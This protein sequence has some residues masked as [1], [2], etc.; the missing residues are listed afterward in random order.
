M[1]GSCSRGQTA[2][3]DGRTTLC[4]ENA[5]MGRCGPRCEVLEPRSLASRF[6]PAEASRP[7]TLQASE[8]IEPFGPTTDKQPL[9]PLSWR[10]EGRARLQK[11]GSLSW[12]LP[13]SA[14]V[15]FTGG[16]RPL[17][18]VLLFRALTSVTPRRGAGG[19]HRST[20]W[21]AAAQRWWPRGGWNRQLLEVGNGW[22]VGQGTC[23]SLKSLENQQG[24]HA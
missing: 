8:C 10:G 1:V 13:P 15:P 17:G 23:C 7:M 12:G 3:R 22:K 20:A 19:G 11:S 18:T 21:Q 24:K 5:S 2:H 14:L 4:A 16:C 9:L 6:Y